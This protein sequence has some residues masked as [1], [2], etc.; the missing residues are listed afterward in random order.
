MELNGRP[1]LMLVWT[2]IYVAV[3]RSV[4]SVKL[5]SPPVDQLKRFSMQL[6]GR[7]HSVEPMPSA[8][9]DGIIISYELI[10]SEY[11]EHERW[12]MMVNHSRR[13]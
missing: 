13:G 11:A 6:S 1:R 2:S 4:E 5:A 8:V 9:V 3:E 7:G 10:E 12:Q